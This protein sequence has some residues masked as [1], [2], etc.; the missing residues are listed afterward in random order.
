[1]SELIN[2]CQQSAIKKAEYAADNKK[3]PLSRNNIE[4]CEHGQSGIML[5]KI[6]FVT[7]VFIGIT[8]I[9]PDSADI[10]DKAIKLISN[11]PALNTV[12]IIA[13]KNLK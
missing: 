11:P 6:A 10:Q 5:L 3:N 8:A 4:N 1:M 2:K 12:K 9:S 13:E 7:L